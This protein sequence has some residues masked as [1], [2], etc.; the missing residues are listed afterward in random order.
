MLICP[1]CKSE[2][3]EGYKVC[4]DCK[5]ELTEIPDVI[6]ERRTVKAAVLIQFIVGLLI[7]LFSPMISYHFTSGY[8]TPKGTSFLTYDPD[9]FLWMLNAYHLSLL[10]AGFIICLP[11]IIYWIKN[12][13]RK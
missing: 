8:F 9:Q 5:C 3:Q 6:E 12:I 11:S 13:I 10:L 1:I 4:S 7:I 2:Y